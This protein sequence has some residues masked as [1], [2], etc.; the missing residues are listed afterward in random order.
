MAE[1]AAP[2]IGIDDAVAAARA[3]YGQSAIRPAHRLLGFS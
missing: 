3:I 1:E 2:V